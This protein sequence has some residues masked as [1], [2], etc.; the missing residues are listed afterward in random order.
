MARVPKLEAMATRDAE[1]RAAADAV[2]EMAIAAVTSSKK[3]RKQ[4]GTSG[5]RLDATIEEARMMRESGDWNEAEPRHLVG[6]FLELHEW[7]YG[8]PAGEEVRKCWAGANGAARRLVAQEFGGNLLAAV[9]FMRW[10]WKRE[11]GREQWRRE[12]GR[13]VRRLTLW[14]ATSSA[15]VTDYRVARRR[16]ER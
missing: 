9:E 10:V 13:P 6:L 15:V 12:N 11:K 2:A 4:M 1:A 5:K 8:V 7:C 16:G 3:R 14:V